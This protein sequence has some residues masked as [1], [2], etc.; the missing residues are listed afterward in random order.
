MIPNRIFAFIVFLLFTTSSFSQN[1]QTLDSLEKVLSQS[2]VDT[3]KVNCMVK[4]ASEYRN[5]EPEKAKQY[6]LKALALAQQNSFKK[7]I[8]NCY[9]LLGMIY[10]HL[11]ENEKAMEYYMFSLKI[12]QE[13]GDKRAMSTSYN[14][15]GSLHYYQGNY[16]KA[17]KYYLISLE[18][19]EELKEERGMASSYNN[20]G[21][22]YWAQSNFDKAQDYFQMA[23]NIYAHLRDKKGLGGAY[24]NIGGVA[25]YK[26][27]PDVAILYFQKSYEYYKDINFK[28]GCATA[29]TNISEILTEQKKYADA[30]KYALESIE[31]H[32]Q[33]GNKSEK[34]YGLLALAKIYSYQKQYPQAIDKLKEVIELSKE[35]NGQ[36]QLS[37]AHLMT[38]QTYYEMGNYKQA[39]QSF[40]AYTT[41]KDSIFTK[42]ST[43]QIAEMNT[44][45]DT[46]KKNKEIELLKKE[47]EIQQLNQEADRSKNAMIRNLL[48]AICAFVLILT[49]VLYNRNQVKQKANLELAEKNKS[50]EEQK[51]QIQFQHSQL[52]HK[53]KEITDSIKYAK[54]LQ[55]A[56]LPPDIQVK[57]L[58]PDSFVLYKPKDIV[59]GD[60]YWIEE[61]GSQILVAAADCTGHGV[62]GAFMSIVGNNL[63]QQAVFNY[64][65]SKP[66]L[67]LNNLNK[68]ISR[69]LHQSAEVVTVKDGMDIALVSIDKATGLVEFSGAFNPLWIVRNNELIEIKGDKQPVGE[70]LGEELQSFTHNEFQTQKG[71]MLYVFTDGFSDQFGGPKGKKFKNKQFQQLL[72]SIASKPMDVQKSILEKTMLD[73]QGNLEQIDD[74][75]VI[76]MRV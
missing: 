54:N 5:N 27:K 53:N 43:A 9:H 19:D 44:K 48:I 47:S 1:K 4:L 37:Q 49:V 61:W 24:S 51:E 70:F 41:A 71:D 26:G 35:I 66:F 8:A 46:D 7:G 68:N 65:L 57:R 56:I 6:A 22:I 67:I 62:P 39:Y 34:T 55:M 17:L 64:G 30:M 58:L 38:A 18:I 59:S 20:V 75:L 25:Y 36:K 11:A 28:T 74:I 60:F 14:N 69:M 29:L 16:D 10:S 15:I 3:V 2:Q 40:E 50:I 72:I 21:L 13:L 31:I 33:L 76:G 52:E 32:E 63:L 42:E 45:Y 23:V 73:W 12:N